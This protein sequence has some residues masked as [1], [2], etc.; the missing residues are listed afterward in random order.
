MYKLFQKI[1]VRD[2]TYTQ[3]D[4]T[5]QYSISSPRTHSSSHCFNILIIIT[6]NAM[7]NSGRRDWERSGLVRWRGAVGLQ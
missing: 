4:T 5:T 2:N 3:K 6:Y 7:L 1:K